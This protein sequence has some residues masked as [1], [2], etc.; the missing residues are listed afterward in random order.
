MLQSFPLMRRRC[1]AAHFHRVSCDSKIFSR[2]IS[3]IEWESQLV[4]GQEHGKP[5]NGV[6]VQDVFFRIFGS[7][8]FSLGYLARRSSQAPDQTKC[9]FCSYSPGGFYIVLQRLSHIL[10]KCKDHNLYDTLGSL[11]PEIHIFQTCQ[12]LMLW[13]IDR[14]SETSKTAKRPQAPRKVGQ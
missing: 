1:M 7:K 4:L 6:G 14:M 3:D 10:D 12:I 9:K 2:P 8:I 13:L 11:G 5:A